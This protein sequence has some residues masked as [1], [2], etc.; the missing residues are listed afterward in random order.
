M[1]SEAARRV[2]EWGDIIRA[3]YAMHEGA[4]HDERLDA[5]AD[6]VEHR[7]AEAVRAV[8]EE[9]AKFA[10]GFAW[11]VNANMHAERHGRAI[12]EELRARAAALREEPK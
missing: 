11:R 6:E 8:W 10:E 2:A 5:I 1:T 9:A 7:V 3:A 4:T 12:A